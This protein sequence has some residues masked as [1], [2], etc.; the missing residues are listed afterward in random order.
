MTDG[1]KSRAKFR[2]TDRVRWIGDPDFYQFEGRVIERFRL[3]G[4]TRY[5]VLTSDKQIYCDERDLE[6]A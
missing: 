6:A 5:L 3:D 2:V 4:R 1:A